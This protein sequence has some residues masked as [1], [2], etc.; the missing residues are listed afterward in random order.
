[1]ALV[2]SQHEYFDCAHSDSAQQDGA[3]WLDFHEHLDHYLGSSRILGGIGRG[4]AEAM[5]DLISK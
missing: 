1:M 5:G 3:F 2:R 4:M